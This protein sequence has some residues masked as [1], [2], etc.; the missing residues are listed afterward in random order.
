M[1]SNKIDVVSLDDIAPDVWDSVAPAD[2]RSPKLLYDWARCTA[3][4]Y[5]RNGALKVIIAG[6]ASRPDAL[7]PLR[8]APGALRRHSFIANDDGGLAI[9]S[10]DAS[11]LPDLAAGLIRLR[12]PI[13][14]GYYPADDPVIDEIR[15]ASRGRA[16]VVLRPQET[17]CAP[18]LDLDPSWEDPDRHLTRNMRQS[19]R[20]NERRLRETGALG[21]DFLEP[22]EHEVDALLDTAVEVEAKSWKDRTGTALAHDARQQAFLRL[23][24]KTAARAGRLHITLVSL[25]GQA[26]AMYI[27]E[28]YGNAFWGYKT[29]FDEAYAKFGPGMLIH[30][31]L[32]RH[33]AGRGVS[34]FEFQGQLVD[35]K[36][37]WTDQ[38]VETVALRIYPF[39][40]R[41]VAAGGYDAVRQRRKRYEAR[42]EAQARANAATV[43]ETPATP[44]PKA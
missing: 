19:I 3:E 26:V 24:A 42:K 4:T 44:K 43:S 32:I 40:P 27:G 7:L 33:L 38:G 29:G 17:P 22:A 21:I 23:Y 15:R 12:E 1:V 16:A 8:V 31:H 35:Y 28:I 14:L 6:S 39:T 36:R 13:D 9:P 30:Y 11:V 2:A 10:R 34:R 18:W 20:R 5:S 41:G 37:R 25:D